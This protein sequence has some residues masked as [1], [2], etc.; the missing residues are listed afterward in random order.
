MCKGS[1]AKT[2][3]SEIGPV[4]IEVLRGRD[5]SFKPVIVPKR[6]CCLDGLDQIVLSPTARGLTPS[7]IA[8]HFDKVYGAR[9]SKDTISQITEKV[10][11]ELAE[12]ANRPLDTIYP[13]IFIDAIVVKV[14]DG[15]VRNTPFYFVMDVTTDGE[16]DIL[17]T[18][19]GDG[20][21][22]ARF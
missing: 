5:G 18:W 15:Q 11:G 4:E 16:R 22:G 6:K 1:R 2:V 10:A 14:R 8:A 3:L 7:E 17:G 13:V 20:Q 9:V 19:A 12:R 21:K